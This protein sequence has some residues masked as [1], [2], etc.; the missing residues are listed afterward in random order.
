MVR[1]E[2]EKGN[3]VLASDATHFYANLEE[4]RPFSI[5]HN[6]SRMYGAFDLVRSLADAPALVVPGHDPR[7]MQRFPAARKGLEGVA[8]HSPENNRQPRRVSCIVRFKRRK[9]VGFYGAEAG[10]ARHG[11]SGGA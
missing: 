4:D 3:V 7:V 11:C 1:V 9:G 10:H 2:T 8:L 5:V 6:L